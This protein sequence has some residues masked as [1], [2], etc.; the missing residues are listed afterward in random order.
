MA[1][2]TSF[3]FSVNNKITDFTFTDNTSFTSPDAREDYAVFVAVYKTDK[4]GNQ[5][6][7]TITPNDPDPTAT[8]SWTGAYQSDGWYQVKY[9]AIPVFVAAQEYNQYDAV[10]SAGQVYISQTDNN[11][12]N[13]VSDTLFWQP[14][15]TP[16]DLVDYVGETN[17]ASNS[18]AELYEEVLYYTSSRTYGLIT[19]KAALNCCESCLRP[20]D[21]EDYEL[22]LIFINAMN[23]ANTQNRYSDGEKIATKALTIKP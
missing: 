6:L 16:T 18:T 20:D 9:V 19:T 15:A 2:T 3:A 22:L 17:E 4:E 23:I 13:A 8:T 11:A 7:I 5:T 14:L 12:N 1:V 10:Y 21:I